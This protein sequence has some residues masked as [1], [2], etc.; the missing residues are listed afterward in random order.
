[1]NC[2][3]CLNSRPVISENGFHRVCCLSDRA[4]YNCI[5]GK[6]DR[7]VEHPML[8]ERDDDATD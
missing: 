5:I 4:S 3:T 6:K 1:M 8:K 2:E 7:Y